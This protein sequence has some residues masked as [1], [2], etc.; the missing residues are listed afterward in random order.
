MKIS[1]TQNLPFHL[2]HIWFLFTFYCTNEFEDHPFWN[3]VDFSKWEFSD[4]QLWRL[5][6]LNMLLFVNYSL[7]TEMIYRKS[8][9]SYF[10]PIS[11]SLKLNFSRSFQFQECMARNKASNWR[12]KAQMPHMTL[13]ISQNYLIIFIIDNVQISSI[14]CIK[15]SIHL[16]IIYC[17]IKVWEL[18]EV[19]EVICLQNTI[20]TACNFLTFCVNS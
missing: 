1:K 17:G 5:C 15:W 18:K 14:L 11:H 2:F 3:A 6:M 13:K 16:E 12:W 19:M 10:C 20:C 7:S 4:A 9:L 8:L